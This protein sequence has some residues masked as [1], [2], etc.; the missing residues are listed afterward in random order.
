MVKGRMTQVF[1]EAVK[2]PS[3][4]PFKKGRGY[5]FPLWKK[6]RRGEL[7]TLT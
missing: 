6:G 2:N 3:Q 1:F 4:S 5:S 7:I